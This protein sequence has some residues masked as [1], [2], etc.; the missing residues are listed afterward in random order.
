MS[1]L[2]VTSRDVLENGWI[3]CAVRTQDR[4]CR[5]QYIWHSMWR[6]LDMLMM[7][8]IMV[9]MLMSWMYVPLILWHQWYVSAYLY[10]IM[11]TCNDL[12]ITYIVLHTF[13][14][15]NWTKNLESNMGHALTNFI[16]QT[17]EMYRFRMSDKLMYN[18]HY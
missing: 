7:M 18:L 9:V 2:K 11:L 13:K 3:E 1:T 5:A 8:L 12:I 17:N 15:S 6:A 4:G 10:G 16:K 14:C